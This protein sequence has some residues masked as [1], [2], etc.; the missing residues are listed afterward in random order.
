MIPLKIFFRTDASVSIGMGHVMRCLTLARALRDRGAECHFI[1][2]E[3][4]NYSFDAIRQAG[5]EATVLSLPV[6][7]H[8]AD[9]TSDKAIFSDIK[10]ISTDWSWDVTQ[11]ISAIQYERPDWLIVD[12][13]FLDARWE[14]A[15]RP[16]CNRLM[17]IDDLADRSHDCDILLDQNFYLDL[18][19][20]YQG[21][22]PEH[23]KKMLGPTY[24]LLRSEFDE[25]RVSLR[26]RDG[27]V[28]RILIFFG[29]TDSK[30]Q[31]KTALEAAVQL[32]RSD[33]SV[34][35]VVGQNNPNRHSIKK[36]CDQLPGVSFHCNVENMAEL[37]A[38]ADLGIGAGGSAMWERCYLGLPTITV[39]VAE[40]QVR[41]TQDVD[42]LG[43]IAYI[44]SAESLSVIDYKHAIHDLIDRPQRLRHM[45]NVAFAIGQN[46][47]ASSVIEEILK[48]SQETN[49]IHPVIFDQNY[50]PI[51]IK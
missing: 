26:V 47:K 38:N 33:I 25:K 12:H 18:H 49:E 19:K 27:K 5:F 7:K 41:S 44:G 13:Y 50:D 6:H 32:G 31:S 30:N 35:L 1:C 48:L 46:R 11:T 9:P 43:A 39:V 2:R 51:L 8:T 15:I 20:R 40:N 42:Q 37:I 17:V 45:S 3:V 34:D 28:R 24:F 22:V 23:C 16:F 14:R 10:W 36:L 21:L 4:P 29:G